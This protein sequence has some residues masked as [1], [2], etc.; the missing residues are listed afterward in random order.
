ME[1]ECLEGQQEPLHT[2][3]RDRKWGKGSRH[4]RL[5]PSASLSLQVGQQ[6]LLGGG[7]PVGGFV[8]GDRWKCQSRLISKSAVTAG[9]RRKKQGELNEVFYKYVLGS[10]FWSRSCLTGNILSV[11]LKSLTV[12]I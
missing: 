9:E 3:K 10:L 5:Q 7:R 1:C 12:R 2:E 11:H 8:I 6:E 4:L